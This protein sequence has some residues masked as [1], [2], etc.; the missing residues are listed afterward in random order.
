MAS[1]VSGYLGLLESPSG[2]VT[3]DTEEQVPPAPPRWRRARLA[4]LA[5]GAVLAVASV[6]IIAKRRDLT[7][8]PKNVRPL[9]LTQDFRR[10]S[11]DFGHWSSSMSM[12]DNA[13]QAWEQFMHSSGFDNELTHTERLQFHDHFVTRAEEVFKDITDPSSDQWSSLMSEIAQDE[14][15]EITEAWVNLINGQDLGFEVEIQPWMEGLTS[16]DVSSRLGLSFPEAPHPEIP[17]RA[18]GFAASGS[19]ASLPRSFSTHEH[20]S[21]CSEVIRRDHNQGQCGSCWAFA[22][23]S[24]L[25]SRLCI[26]T[27]GAFSGVQAHLSRTYATSCSLSSDGCQGG[28]SHKAFTLAATHGLPTGGP[29]GCAPYFGSGEGTDHFNQQDRAPPCPGECTRTGYARSLSADKFK[30]G[31]GDDGYYFRDESYHSRATTSRVHTIMQEL[32]EGGPVVAYVYVGKAFMGYKSGI[33][34]A[35]CHQDAGNHAVST[36]GFGGNDCSRGYA[37]CRGFYWTLLNS[38]GDHWGNGGEMKVASCVT[39]SFDVPGA[40]TSADIQNLPNPLLPGSPDTR[41]R[42]GVSPSPPPP[43]PAPPAGNFQV[44]SG[45]C[46]VEAGCVSSP[47]FPH[48]YHNN[49][50]CAIKVSAPTVLNVV[51]F[52]TEGGYDTLIVNNRKYSGGHHPHGQTASGTMHWISDDSMNDHGWKVCS[53]PPPVHDQADCSTTFDDLEAEHGTMKIHCPSSC[54]P[55]AGTVWGTNPYTTD[56]SLCLAARHAGRTGL[57]SFR[58]TGHRRN[59][60]YS[61]RNGVQSVGYMGTWSSFQIL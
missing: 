51:A 58:Y 22:A 8:L 31:T 20:W 37:N 12:Q 36:L 52:S 2:E 59:Y 49:E 9:L 13:N 11:L 41:R 46:K 1:G 23:L 3:V 26:K 19:S 34:N 24:V 17:D 25:D 47:H 15:P 18:K 44:T 27:D 28:W 29:R 42:R 16:R 45:G 39:T 6:G 7:K 32:M 48:P 30:F 50:H 35:D 43:P 14:K 57:I 40:I 54:H 10:L 21:K 56:S 55:S 61:H 5:V 53:L 38:W 33:L 4:L 60:P